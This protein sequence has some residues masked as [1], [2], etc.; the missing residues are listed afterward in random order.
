MQTRIADTLVL[1]FTRGVSLAQWRSGGGLARELALYEAIAGRYERFIFLTYGGPDEAE[2]LAQSGFPALA[3]KTTVICNSAGKKQGE[4]AAEAPGLV[5]AA[6][7]AGKRIV[8]KT[9]QLKGGSLAVRVAEAVRAAGSEAAL[10]AR[11]G[12]LWSRFVAH[13]Q[14]SGCEEARR[15]SEEEGELCRAADLIVAPPA[16]WSK[17]LPGGTASNSTACVWCPTTSMWRQH[18][19][20]PANASRAPCSTPGSSSRANAWR[21]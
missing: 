21:C 18:R 12:Y 1:V 4:F 13:E 16:A 20:R 8:V 19:P 6:V 7:G 10:I 3:S 17:T 2:I 11:G 15:A 5:A 9:N 14:G